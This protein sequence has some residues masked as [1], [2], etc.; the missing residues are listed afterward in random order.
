V[1]YTSGSTGRPKGVVVTH[2]GLANYLAGWVLAAYPVTAGRGAAVSSS[3]AF[4]LSV[5]GI[6][7][8][9]LAGR[10]VWL[11]PEGAETEGL[12]SMLRDI[13]GFSFVKLTPAHVDLLGQ[14][15]TAAEAAKAASALVVGGE[16][17]RARTVSLWIKSA[18][19]TVIFNEYGPTEATVGC[20]VYR[21]PQ[22][23]TLSR[24]VPIGR[25]IANTALYILD[26]C[27]RPT[28]VGV[29]GELH[30]G[31]DG[32]ARG[33]LGGAQITAERFI[34]AP[35]GNQPGARIYKTGDLARYNA[36]GNIEF[37]GRNDSQIKIRGYRIELGEIEAGLLEHPSVKDAAAVAYVDATGEKRIVACVTPRE[38]GPAEEAELRTHLSARLPGYMIPSAIVWLDQLPLTANGK[39]DSKALAALGQNAKLEPAKR[40]VAPRSTAEARLASIWAEVLGVDRVGIHDSFFELGGH[41][42]M[43]GQV[44]ARVRKMFHVELLPRSF[45]DSP[46]VAEQVVAIAM[47]QAELTGDEEVARV[48]SELRPRT[49]SSAD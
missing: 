39:I 22:S 48:L 26:R 49:A 9:L 24:S 37:I 31:G 28:P 15:L 33:Y 8:P 17:L 40:Y 25:P 12:A 20:C 46:T 29:P 35:F 1:I 43:I 47:K 10:E 4:D 38:A 18:P 19:Q 2:R 27:L 16:P 14:Q 5:T 36:D 21:V 11:V 23:Q 30:I 34:P 45:F 7:A 44:T 42:L 32:L 6:F 13:G 3:I 41:S